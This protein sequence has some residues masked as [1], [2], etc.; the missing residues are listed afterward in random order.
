MEKMHTEFLLS[1]TG[2]GGKEASE[3]AA[4]EEGVGMEDAVMAELCGEKL[5]WLEEG[6]NVLYGR[7][8]ALSGLER[9]TDAWN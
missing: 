8:L 5:K 4:A 7:K 1:F 3:V 9:R 6:A 2:T